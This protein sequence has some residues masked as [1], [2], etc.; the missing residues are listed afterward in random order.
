MSNMMRHKDATDRK[1]PNRRRSYEDPSDVFIGDL[2]RLAGVVVDWLVRARRRELINMI[3]AL[4]RRRDRGRGRRLGFGAEK[5][6]K[7]NSR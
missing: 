4:Q 3:T 2:L 1:I 6:A 7:K 5:K